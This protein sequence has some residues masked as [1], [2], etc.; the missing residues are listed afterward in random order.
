MT[1]LS[2]EANE[3]TEAAAANESELVGGAGIVAE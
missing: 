2:D 3:V 1:K